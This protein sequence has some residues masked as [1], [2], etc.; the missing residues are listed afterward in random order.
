MLPSPAELTYFFEIA[1]KLN[2]SK[3]A[4]TLGVSQSSLSFAIQKLEKTLGVSLF[5]R[6]KHGV[7]LTRSGEK[8]FCRTKKLLAEWEETCQQTTD[9]HQSLKGITTIGCNTTI[10]FFLHI[11][12]RPLLDRNPE[13]TF[14]LKH[15][16]STETTL[17]V[18]NSKVDIGFVVNPS[19]HPDLIIRKLFRSEMAC[20]KNDT[21]HDI[22]NIHSNKLVVICDTNLPQT[23]NILKKLRKQIAHPMRIM[24]VNSL[25]VIA[26]LTIQ[27]CGIGILPACFVQNSY[28]NKL[29]RLMDMP[30][31]MYDLY[32]IYR[33]EN[34]N[35]KIIEIVIDEIKKIYPNIK[36]SS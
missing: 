9:A 32:L 19:K 16:I 18:I 1:N 10:G 3:A 28:A 31:C 13:L 15:D 26:H 36:I 5:I 7:T 17:D 21:L 34:R 33:K 14:H 4:I 2:V 25:E 24:S 6:H 30:V 11:L 27:G 12:L 8:L 20:W 23:Q 35:V 22:Q 29:R